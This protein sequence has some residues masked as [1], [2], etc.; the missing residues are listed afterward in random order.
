M[1]IFK[2]S[3]QH[4]DMKLKKAGFKTYTAAESMKQQQKK[5]GIITMH[6][7]IN[8]GSALQTYATVKA[9][10]KVGFAPSVINYLY[11]SNYHLE[12]AAGDENVDRKSRKEQVKR[13]CRKMGV[14]EVM[15]FFWSLVCKNPRKK[16][17]RA[18]IRKMN[19]TKKYTIKSI[20]KNPPVFDIYLTGSDQTWN[21]RYL[22]HDYSFLLNWVPD[23]APKISYAAS[24]GSKTLPA[25]FHEPYKRYLGRY[26]HISVR[27][28]SGVKLVKELCGREAV[29]VLDPTL[30]LCG[31]DWKKLIVDIPELP[32]HFIFCYC[33]N[34]VFDPS[35]D[36][37]TLLEHLR[38]LLN[39]EVLFFSEAVSLKDAAAKAGYKNVLPLSPEEFVTYYAKAGFIV[40]TS[41]HGAAFAVNLNK[42]FY[43]QLN[44]NPSQDDR[45]INFLEEIEMSDRGLNLREIDVNKITTGDLNI[46]YGAG[47]LTLEKMRKSSLDYLREALVFAGQRKKYKGF[48]VLK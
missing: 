38:V 10:E 40:S 3:K 17:F 41:F 29:H 2:T 6:R 19:L 23:H 30:L 25:E 24:F 1:G 9:V 13:I 8:Y 43:I 21:P 31:E 12:Y 27:E 20:L 39:C 4:P 44:P 45:V 48:E 42:N 26:D 32:D 28:S 35:P 15:R 46:D 5:V 34:Y 16:F 47:N 18:F 36:I 22:G 11:P 14:I 7:V 33:L 37:F